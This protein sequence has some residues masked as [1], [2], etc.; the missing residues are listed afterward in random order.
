M[1]LSAMANLAVGAARSA[2]ELIITRRGDSTR[3]FKNTHVGS[4]DY[5]TE[6]DLAS[7]ALLRKA[8]ERSKLS[9]HGEETAGHDVNDGWC[10]VV[11]PIDGTLNWANNLPFC[12]ISIGLC[13]NG[14]PVLGVIHTPL[15][16]GRTWVGVVGE[17]ASCDGRAV[18][19]NDVDPREA[20][21]AYDGVRGNGPDPYL[22]AL[23]GAV[24][25]HRL[26]GSTA[27]EMALCADGGFAAV[28]APSAMFWDVAAGIALVQAAGG[29]AVALDGGEPVPGSGSVVVGSARTV[30]AVVNAISSIGDPNR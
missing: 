25:R 18:S 27:T 5:A 15:L 3:T 17:G 21:I 16:N 1:D 10:W 23:R 22:A 30:D 4:I 8:L 2:G 14:V 20:V 9:F 26:L 24:G 6:T 19:V 11:D 28:V 12:A 7:E 13:H 29:K